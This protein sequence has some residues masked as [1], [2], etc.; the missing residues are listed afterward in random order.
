MKIFKAIIEFFKNLFKKKEK[1]VPVPVNN[2][3]EWNAMEKNIAT[4]MN[5]IREE[6]KPLSLIKRIGG[7][8]YSPLNVIP[9]LIPNKLLWEEARKRCV[10]QFGREKISHDGVGVAFKVILDAGYLAPGE[11]L[12]YGYST[13]E[14]VLEAWYNSLSH[15]K[16]MLR[17][18]YKYYGVA[19]VENNGKKYY[20]VLFCK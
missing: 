4:F 20:C 17:S 16:V 6:S 13:A 5:I 15:K 19:Y 2:F 18:S 8:F 12:A 9:D 10:A 11:I 3:D 7:V 1:V 14:S